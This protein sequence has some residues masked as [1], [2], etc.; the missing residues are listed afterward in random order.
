MVSASLVGPEISDMANNI[1]EVGTVNYS[2]GLSSLPNVCHLI[3]K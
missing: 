2:L 1:T 3:F